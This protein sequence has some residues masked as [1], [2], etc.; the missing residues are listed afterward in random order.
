MPHLQP[1]VPPGTTSGASTWPPP[2]PP[3]PP[4]TGQYSLTP[5]QSPG[6]SILNICIPCS[7]Q[8]LALRRNQLPAPHAIRPS[9]SGIPPHSYQ[10]RDDSFSPPPPTLPEPRPPPASL[11]PAFIDMLANELGFGEE[12]QEFRMKLHGFSQVIH[13]CRIYSTLL[14][15]LLAGL[16]SSQAR[17]CHTSVRFRSI[18]RDA[19]KCTGC[20]PECHQGTKPL[21]R[22]LPAP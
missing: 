16:R 13:L 9:D 7:N 18:I 19:E 11:A 17:S 15:A 4:A 2:P 10:F 22:H 20:Q 12:D 21:D 8:F 5:Q 3:P 14:T 1:P 6:K